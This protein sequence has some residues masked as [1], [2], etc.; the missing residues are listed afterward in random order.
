MRNRSNQEWLTDLR[1]PGPAQE[2]ALADL[3]AVILAG[4]PYA[5]SRYLSSS[6]PQFNALTEEVTQET[7]LRVLANLDSFE[8]RSRFT[9]W[10]HAIA[11]RLALS[12]L[13][14]Q[15][16]RDVSLDEMVSGGENELEP[17]TAGV[18]ADTAPGTELTAERADLLARVLRVISE[19]LTEKQRSAMVLLA[20]RGMPL[21]EAARRL[22]MNPNALYK[23]MHDAR[24]R[25][26]K[27]LEAE[28]LHPADVLSAFEEK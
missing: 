24:L 14:H 3:R 19:E 9:T 26:K 27:R 28:G 6:D 11:V 13:R 4:L 22:D 7:L 20:I 17:E 12:E 16:W 23:L 15:K 25:L 1:S 8:G 21:E 5:L 18:L 2:A 10:V